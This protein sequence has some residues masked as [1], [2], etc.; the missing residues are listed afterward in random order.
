[1]L[2]LFN[3]D[4]EDSEAG[5]SLFEIV[6]LTHIFIGSAAVLLGIFIALRANG[7]VP[8]ILQFRNYKTPMRVSYALYMVAILLGIWVYVA[9]PD[10]VGA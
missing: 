10:R 8:K 7:F 4:E 5:I 9:M 1:V 2:R 3:P 6:L